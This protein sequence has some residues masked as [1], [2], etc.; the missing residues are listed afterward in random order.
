MSKPVCL[1]LG[2]GAGIGGTVGRRFA[3]EGYHAVLCR[4]SNEAGLA[5]LVDAIEDDGGS[6]TGFIRMAG[7][8]VLGEIHHLGPR[9]QHQCSHASNRPGPRAQEKIGEG[10]PQCALLRLLTIFSTV[11]TLGDIAR[12]IHLAGGPPHDAQ[13]EH[14]G[15]EGNTQ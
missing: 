10:I 15:R 1:V 13:R 12:A 4:R 6:A 9:V 5:T 2:A 7:R 3:R 8:E 11:Q 14:E